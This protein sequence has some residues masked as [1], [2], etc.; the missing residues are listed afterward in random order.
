M[1]TPAPSARVVT[2]DLATRPNAGP[3]DRL[4]AI[5]VPALA[6]LA[7]WLLAYP[8]Q[9]LTG[10]AQLYAAQAL[11]ALQPDLFDRDLFFRFGSQDAFTVFSHAYAPLVEALSPGRAHLVGAL[12]LRLLWLAALVWLMLRLFPPR[13]A[14]V[15]GCAVAVLPSDYSALSLIGYA[16][17]F[18]TARPVAEII[19]LVAIGQWLAGRPVVALALTLVSIPIHPLI[20]LPAAG[21]VIIATALRDPRWWWLAAAGGAAAIGAATLG[22]D[23]AS[24]LFDAIDDRWLAA[25]AAANPSVLSE[26]WDEAMWAGTIFTM[27]ALLL[28]ATLLEG[29]L[30]TLCRAAALT[31]AA[32]L[33]ASL[34]FG[35]GL[36]SLLVLQVQPWRAAWLA[37]PLGWIALA[38]CAVRIWRTAGHRR[39]ALIL[40]ASALAA[41]ETLPVGVCLLVTAFLYIEADRRGWLSALSRSV[42]IGIAIVA[43]VLASPSLIAPV[44]VLA[45]AAPAVELHAWL[46][47]VL[48]HPV[49]GAAIVGA[50]LLLVRPW[51]G[52]V[53]LVLTG[54][55]AV[56]AVT[57]A[58][59]WDQRG[60][61]ERAVEDDGAPPAFRA[62]LPED[63]LVY[64]DLGAWM[65][66]FGLNRPAYVA[67]VHG[68]GLVLSRER[69]QAYRDRSAEIAPFAP[70]TAEATRRDWPARPTDAPDAQRVTALCTAIPAID[71]LVLRYGFDGLV[72]AQWTLPAPFRHVSFV[73]GADGLETE[74]V[75]VTDLYLYD[76]AAIRS[77]GAL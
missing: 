22:I 34:V 5:A 33:A 60:T 37:Q 4:P 20:G 65:A 36:R 54:L 64:T 24:R 14:L 76:C 21:I 26:T 28:A 2:D 57:A 49:I 39:V 63:A 42:H 40:L 25:V 16:E 75:V 38:A 23:P 66:W 56:G 73:G 50:V 71:A 29:P 13:L 43:V 27:A 48:R 69:S 19:G 74:A 35:E 45:Y 53:P 55:L 1:K 52:P 77:G 31:L 46:P 44:A 15:V 41:R 18:V 68:S 9:G 3:L 59:G 6:L 70:I 8:H 51:P 67:R 32:G 58:L 7:L 10:D 62:R 12:A 17:P 72:T 61:A 30:R 47:V 11:H